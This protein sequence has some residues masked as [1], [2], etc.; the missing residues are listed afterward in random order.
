MFLRKTG[1]PDGLSGFLFLRDETMKDLFE[2]LNRHNFR[3]GRMTSEQGHKV[4]GPHAF[5]SIDR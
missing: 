3:N 1:E 5:G 2:L 4:M